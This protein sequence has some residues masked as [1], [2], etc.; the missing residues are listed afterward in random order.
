MS[1]A[2]IF[3]P[4]KAYTGAAELEQ[5][6]TGSRTIYVCDFYVTGAEQGIPEPGGFRIGRIL[7]VDHHAPH[8]R[9]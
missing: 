3:V 2:P 6:C 9:M 7:N 1:V 8:P 5:R 4:L